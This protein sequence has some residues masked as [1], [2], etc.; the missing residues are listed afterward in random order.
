MP[1]LPAS[2]FVK[3]PGKTRTFILEGDNLP[4]VVKNLKLA[5]VFEVIRERNKIFIFSQRLGKIAKI[6]ESALVA[7][8]NFAVESKARLEA[9]FV[10][11]TKNEK[12]K[13]RLQFIL[14]SSLPIF[15]NEKITGLKPFWRGSEV[16]GDRKT[17]EGKVPEENVNEEEALTEEETNPLSGLNIVGEKP[18]HSEE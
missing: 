10:S 18:S 9:I 15:A 5:D 11:L 6:E 2:I 8:L 16:D 14:R 3:E 17:D 7:K 13:P 12:G 1:A 4:K